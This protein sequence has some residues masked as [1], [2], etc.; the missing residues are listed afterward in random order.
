[1]VISM[2]Q[3]LYSIYL[4]NRRLDGTYSWSGCFGDKKNLLFMVII[5]S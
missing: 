4:L 2:P 1:V 3:P 5:D